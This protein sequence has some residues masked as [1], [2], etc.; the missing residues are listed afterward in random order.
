MIRFYV[1]TRPVV[2]PSN[3]YE[4]DFQELQKNNLP[5]FGFGDRPKKNNR[6]FT[7]F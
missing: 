7:F 5:V 6:Y 2:I 3:G 1:F 4:I